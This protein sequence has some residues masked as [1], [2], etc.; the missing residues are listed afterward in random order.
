MRALSGAI[1]NHPIAEFRVPNVLPKTDAQFLTGPDSA[2][3]GAAA[4]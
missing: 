2:T 3:L 1:E 4:A